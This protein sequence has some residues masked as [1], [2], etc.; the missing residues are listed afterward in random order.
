MCVDLQNVD[1]IFQCQFK[2]L[3]VNTFKGLSYFEKTQKIQSRW[4]VK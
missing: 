2:K 4:A 3:L 1:E